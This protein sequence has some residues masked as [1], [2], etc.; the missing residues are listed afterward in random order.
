MA[1]SQAAPSQNQHQT[2]APR[3]TPVKDA[4]ISQCD[5]R[6]D[7]NTSQLPCL[8]AGEGTVGG[9]LPQDLPAFRQGTGWGRAR[10]IAP[11][12]QEMRA[13]LARP[14]SEEVPTHRESLKMFRSTL[15]R[16]CCLDSLE[17]TLLWN[18]GSARLVLRHHT[19]SFPKHT[20]NH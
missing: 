18:T 2:F 4:G 15:W 14:S 7:G 9:Q 5:T 19:D 11:K 12:G 13:A 17:V 8:A 10:L 20:V 6:I 16:G 1:D 3:H